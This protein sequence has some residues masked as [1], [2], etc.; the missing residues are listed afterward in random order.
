MWV[1]FGNSDIDVIMVHEAGPDN[2]LASCPLYG[3]TVLLTLL[4]LSS[5]APQRIHVPCH[6]HHAC[7]STRLVDDMITL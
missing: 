3:G 7:S 4:V 1:D 2:W 6:P 5:A